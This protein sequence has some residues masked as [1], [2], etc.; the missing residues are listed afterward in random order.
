[1][2]SW[3]PEGAVGLFPAFAIAVEIIP[4]GSPDNELLDKSEDASLGGA[5]SYLVATQV[6]SVLK[7]AH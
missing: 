4:A 6:A 1:M 2:F 3:P 7:Y 5:D